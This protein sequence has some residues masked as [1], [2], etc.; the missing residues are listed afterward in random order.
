MAKKP[1]E[2]SAANDPQVVDK[3]K[4]VEVA[5]QLAVSRGWG[6]VS[7]A[8]VAQAANISLADLYDMFDDKTDILVALG[9]MIDK[10]VLAN[11]SE[12]DPSISEK[13][14]LFEILMERFDALSEHREGVIAVLTSFRLDPK[15]AVISLPHLARSM[16]WMLE[17]AQ[18]ETS[19]II[20]AVKVTGLTGVYLKALKSWMDDDS[21]DLSKT[22]AS[23]DKG[24]SRAEQLVNILSL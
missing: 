6:S 3:P 24:L 5:L 13:D 22:M 11:I 9:R 8:E 17:A 1:L 18:I 15:Q 4:V 14:R 16:S 20:G 19:G 12:F 23:L 21:P 2:K 10:A 7:M